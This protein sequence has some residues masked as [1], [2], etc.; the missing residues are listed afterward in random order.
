MTSIITGDIIN[1]RKL[2]TSVWM[3]GLKHTLSQYGSQPG[4]WEIYRGD[5]FQLEIDPQLAFRAA[6]HIKAYLKTL[7]L[8]AR[9]SIGLGEKT[10]QATKISESNGSAFVRSGEYFEQL[11]KLKNNLTINTG[12]AIL[13][14]EINLMLRL[15]QT[16]MNHWL[17]QSAELVLLAIENPTWSQEEMGNKLKI[18]QAAVSKRRKRAQFD[19]ILE[20][21]QYYQEKIKSL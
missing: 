10:Y 15:A 18:N 7:K 5:A 6:I 3:E 14:Q 11:K 16:F 20:L 2:A 13:N 8:D 1:S 19:L 4:S 21:E 12:N 17:A 9:M